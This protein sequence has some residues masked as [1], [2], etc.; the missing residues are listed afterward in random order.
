MIFLNQHIC[1]NNNNIML[2]YMSNKSKMN[3]ND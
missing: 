2:S 3:N 1:L